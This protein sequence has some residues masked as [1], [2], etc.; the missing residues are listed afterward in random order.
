V[1]DSVNQPTAS[2]AGRRG[3]AVLNAGLSFVHLIGIVGFAVA[4]VVQL[5]QHGTGGLHLATLEN[6][7]VW[8][9]GVNGIVAGSGHLLFADPVARSIGWTEGTPWQWEVGLAGLGW[10]VLGVM[11]PAYDR[12]F[13]LATIIV[14]SIFLIGA[15]VGHIRQIVTAH[16]LAPSNAGPILFTDVLLPCAVILLY[17]TY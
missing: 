15:A 7:L 10:G 2:G 17:V 9:I 12:D 1:G 16:N 6:A 8:L 3:P 14:S 13:W 11:A 4:E 5:L